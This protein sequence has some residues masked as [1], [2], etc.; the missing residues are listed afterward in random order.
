M[1]LASLGPDLPDGYGGYGQAMVSNDEAVYFI[2][3]EKSVI[4][5]LACTIPDQILQCQWL[6]FEHNLEAPR[7]FA[8]IFMI[9][10]FLTDCENEK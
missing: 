6:K 3:T 7:N 10:D 4:F 5:R 2:N 1:C 9:P 8:S